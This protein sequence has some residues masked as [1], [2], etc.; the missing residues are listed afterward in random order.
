MNKFLATGEEL[1][2]VIRKLLG[3]EKFKKRNITNSI[4]I[5]HKAQTKRCL[6][7]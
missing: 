6:I 3:E 7:D 5:L 1:P 4:N 2:D